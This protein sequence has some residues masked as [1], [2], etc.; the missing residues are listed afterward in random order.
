MRKRPWW[1]FHPMQ[2]I[3]ALSL[4]PGLGACGAACLVATRLL[5]QTIPDIAYQQVGNLESSLDRY[6]RN[7][8]AFPSEAQGFQ[9]L[10]DVGLLEKL[11]LDPWGR[12]YRYSLRAGPDGGVGPRVSSDGK[13][14][15]P[16]TEDD[17]GPR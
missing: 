5:E 17:V 4:L 15:L 16:G 13:D 10:V 7:E 14:G 8:G 9:R 11:P 2:H 1:W 3:V 12:P 6:R